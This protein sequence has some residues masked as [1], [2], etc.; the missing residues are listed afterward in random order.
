MRWSIK[1][2][3]NSICWKF[4]FHDLKARFNFIDP[5]NVSFFFFLSLR[6]WRFSFWKNPA[7][8][9]Y[10][11]LNFT[12]YRLEKNRLKNFKTKKS[13]FL[14]LMMFKRKTKKIENHHKSHE[15]QDLVINIPN[16]NVEWTEKRNSQMIFIFNK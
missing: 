13:T 3:Q 11:Q 14:L 1:N 7:F 16:T 9:F 4:E 8:F 10:S 6:S 2:A 5:Q 15:K 12:I